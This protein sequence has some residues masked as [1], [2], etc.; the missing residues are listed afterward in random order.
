MYLIY[1]LKWTT[2]YSYYVKLLCYLLINSFRVYNSD[3]II[4]AN[5][6]TILMILI[7]KS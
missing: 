3:K 7:G 2:T 5:F 6:K 4:F 1:I